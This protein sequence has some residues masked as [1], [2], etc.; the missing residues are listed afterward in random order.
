MRGKKRGKKE[1]EKEKEKGGGTYTVPSP[2]QRSLW[3][4]LP[5]STKLTT[6]APASGWGQSREL[7]NRTR[8]DPESC[9]AVPDTHQ[10]THHTI[11]QHTTPHC[12]Q[13]WSR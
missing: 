8:N 3:Q 12:W 6:R 1:K 7:A 10:A 4:H 2:R 13:Q 9:A 5:R 11:P